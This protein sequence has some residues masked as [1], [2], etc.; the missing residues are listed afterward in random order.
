MKVESVLDYQLTDS[1]ERQSERMD[2]SNAKHEI[3]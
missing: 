3:P 2:L 1:Q